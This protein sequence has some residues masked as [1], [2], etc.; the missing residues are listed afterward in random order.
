MKNK[1]INW[2]IILILLSLNIIP[3][4]SGIEFTRSNKFLSNEEGTLSGYIWDK[5][6]NPIEGSEV[7]VYFHEKYEKNFSDSSGYYHVTNI[8]I[9]FC[10]KNAT[11]YKEGYK[12]EWVL[13]AIGENTIHNFTLKPLNKKLFVGGIGPNNYSRIQD[14]IDNAS[15]GY[16]I[17]VYNGTYFENIIINKAIDLIGENKVTTIIDADN[18]GDVISI[19][20]DNVC[21]SGF[22]IL[23]SGI[24]E[25]PFYEFQGIFIDSNK[26]KIVGN[27]IYNT[28]QGIN[29]NSS[30]GNIIQANVIDNCISHGIYQFNSFNN[31]ISNN[32]ILNCNYSGITL[33]VSDNN[34]ISH[35]T[36]SYSIYEH[37]ILLSISNNNT[38]T[39]N[40]I[41]ENRFGIKISISEDNNILSNN[42]LD[43]KR[44]AKFYALSSNSKNLWDGNFWDHARILP[45]IICGSFFIEENRIWLHGIN[46]DWHPSKEPYEI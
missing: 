40:S 7:V 27:I 28:E 31:Y 33:V 2:G 35:N 46:I 25:Y 18:N 15:S 26:N 34:I 8:P 3:L 43:N 45:K 30:F 1:P 36:I 39:K 5:N 16:T 42:F 41:I 19:F 38:I 12:S 9:C 13:L 10:L 4:V 17:F 14:A 11:V 32:F 21:I 29:L 22:T 23:N 6:M 37:G 20:S 44:S 24:S